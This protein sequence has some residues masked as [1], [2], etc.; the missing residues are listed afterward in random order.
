MDRDQIINALGCCSERFG[1]CDECPY[2]EEEYCEA[3]MR[4]DALALIRELIDENELLKAGISTEFTCVFGTPHKVGD[5]PIDEEVAKAKADT[6]R[7]MA[8]RIKDAMNNV[9][10]WSFHNDPNEYFIIGK[11]FIDQIADEMLEGEE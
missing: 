5:C 6:V 8:E 1:M 10:R 7:E 2:E 11:P 3:E 4:S 9:S